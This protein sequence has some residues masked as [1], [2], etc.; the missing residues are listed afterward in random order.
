MKIS[1]DA[2]ADALSIIFRETT[3][4]T[5][6]LAEGIAAPTAAMRA[7]TSSTNSC[8]TGSPAASPAPAPR[9]SAGLPPSYALGCA[10]PARCV[11]G[12]A[13]N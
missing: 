7:A 1:Y 8:A 11:A 2:D 10:L 13:K 12:A 4:T 9:F 6:H 3:V 5:K